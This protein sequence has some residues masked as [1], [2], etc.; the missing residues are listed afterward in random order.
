MERSLHL[1]L[2]HES[3]DEPMTD[4]NNPTFYVERY[5]D[6]KGD[7]LFSKALVFVWASH[8]FVIEWWR[9]RR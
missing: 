7:G 6:H 3:S 9:T 5:N 2:S 8:S 1:R 4:L